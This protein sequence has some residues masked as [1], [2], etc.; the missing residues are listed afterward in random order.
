LPF[1]LI[2]SWV[3]GTLIITKTGDLAGSR[4]SSI[5]AMLETAWIIQDDLKR[6]YY[7]G[8]SFNI[9]EFEPTIPG[10]LSKAP[11]AIASGLFRP[12]L[13]EGKRTILM[14]IS[15]IENLLLLLII[16]YV[17]LKLKFI[18]FFKLLFKD[19]LMIAL[20]TLSITFAFSVGLTT[21]NFGAL[22]RY[23][24]PAKGI[25]IIVFSYMLNEINLYYSQ[26]KKENT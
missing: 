14:T 22:V 15:G 6:D 8:N 25:L 2:A 17:L 10:V 1:I 12:F 21:S 3:A 4:Y 18:F 20:F 23:A 11:I 16:V 26:K 7:G 5:D 24:I 13:W 19:P 9:G